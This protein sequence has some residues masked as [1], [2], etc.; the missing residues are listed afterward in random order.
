MY[1]P[2]VTTVAFAGRDGMSMNLQY[3]VSAGDEAEARTEIQRRLINQ[4]ICNYSI[5]EVRRATRDEAALLNL[6]AG[7]IRLLN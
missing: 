3:G 7:S 2:F 1:T 4:E 6:P 5:V